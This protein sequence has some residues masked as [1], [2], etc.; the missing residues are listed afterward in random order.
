MIHHENIQKYT[1]TLEDLATELGDLRYD[2]LANFLHAFSKKI[3]TDAAKDRSRKRIKLAKS[4]EQ[5]AV[6]LEQSAT[7]IE[8]AWRICKPFMKY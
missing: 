3:A 8:E 7:E 4:L 2:A 6:Y 5:S 1:G